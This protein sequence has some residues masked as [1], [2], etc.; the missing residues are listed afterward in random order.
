MIY[1]IR[2]CLTFYWHMWG[3]NVGALRVKTRT[4]NGIYSTPFW[5]RGY[6]YGDN[7]NIAQVEVSSFD[8]YQVVFEGVVDDTWLGDIAIGNLKY[9]PFK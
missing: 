1:N 6:N 4:S 5:S 7:W 9:Y 3:D 8:I 2:Q